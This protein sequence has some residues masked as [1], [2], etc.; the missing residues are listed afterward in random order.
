MRVVA[1][2]PGV[3]RV[4]AFQDE[5]PIEFDETPSVTAAHWSD[6]AVTA[7]AGSPV[8]GVW[9]VTVA[10]DTPGR[11]TV[12]LSGVVGGAAWSRAVDVDVVSER[13]FD[14]SALAELPGMDAARW[15]VDVKAAAR[16]WVESQVELVTGTSVVVAPHVERGRACD[17]VLVGGGLRLAERYPVVVVALF[18]DGVEVDVSSAR[19][20]GD[21][22]VWGVD[23][24]SA[25]DVEVWMLRGA[26]S[27]PPADLAAAC[28]QWAAARVAGTGDGG[29]PARAVSVTNELESFR[30]ATASV[31]RPSGIPEVDAVVVGWRDRLR[32]PGVA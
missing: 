16:D 3:V 13:L 12:A 6:A 2:Q 10:C 14:L 15:S 24:G 28:A 27:V 1:G 4:R 11:V 29:I 8:G 30:L 23:V 17:L 25:V 7:A 22:V 26:F 31:D 32:L 21:G 20:V 5:D 19:C 9:P 18:A